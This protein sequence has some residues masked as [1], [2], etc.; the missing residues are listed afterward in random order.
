M[1]FKRFNKLTEDEFVLL[2]GT[3]KLAEMLSNKF[4][5][6]DTSAI[7]WLEENAMWQWCCVSHGPG[8]ILY[9]ESA[10]DAHLLNQHLNSSN[11]SSEPPIHSI[12]IVHEQN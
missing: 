3:E 6:D 11:T 12:N 2:K 8:Y 9:F 5:T 10:E 7:D 4:Y 1:T